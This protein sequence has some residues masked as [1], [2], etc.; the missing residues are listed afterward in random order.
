MWPESTTAPTLR[1]EIVVENDEDLPS[2]LAHVVKEPDSS[3]RCMVI[4][5][6]G[7]LVI[8]PIVFNLHV[9]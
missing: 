6:F 2:W 1:Q 4:N 5:S 3:A 9:I 7:L 8:L